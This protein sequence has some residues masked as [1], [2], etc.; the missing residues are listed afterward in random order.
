MW[1][2]C[3]DGI[4][5]ASDSDVGGDDGDGGGDGGVGKPNACGGCG[6]IR[7]YRAAVPNSRYYDPGRPAVCL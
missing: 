6:V 1:L 2:H 5:V 3:G 7:L 4:G